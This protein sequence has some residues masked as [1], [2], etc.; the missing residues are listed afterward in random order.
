MR[1]ERFSA[2]SKVLEAFR[3]EDEGKKIGL[4]EDETIEP[5]LDV[6][7]D[8]GL[9]VHG[10]R[11]SDVLVHHYFYHWFMIYAEPLE[12]YFD[13][14]HREHRPEYKYLRRLYDR[15][16]SFERLDLGW[17]GIPYM[18]KLGPIKEKYILDEIEENKPEQ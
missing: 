8:L 15:M 17:F 5:V 16:R 4:S 3:E 1:E 13:C 6:F 11:I 9:L 12:A 2:C 18:G 7:E 10:N 14:L